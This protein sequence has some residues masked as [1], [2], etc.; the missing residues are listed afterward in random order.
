MTLN[1]TQ[2]YL[3]RQLLHRS[4]KVDSPLKV[5]ASIC[6]INAQRTPT[7]YLSCWNRIENFQKEELDKAFYVVATIVNGAFHECWVE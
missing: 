3:E 2:L 1:L 4:T 7:I 5:A 6:G